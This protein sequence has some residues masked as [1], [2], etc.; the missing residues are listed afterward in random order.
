MKKSHSMGLLF[1]YRLHAAS[2]KCCSWCNGGIHW[3]FCW[4]VQQSH[5]ILAYSGTRGHFAPLHESPWTHMGACS[6]S[7]A[8]TQHCFTQVMVP[9]VSPR[10]GIERGWRY[11]TSICSR[12]RYP[13]QNVPEY[14]AKLFKGWPIVTLP[15][16]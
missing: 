15:R 11:E 7:D 16:Y 1:S 13:F 6:C 3:I 8:S 2:P 9:V 4:F 12:S 14:Q 10:A 5:G